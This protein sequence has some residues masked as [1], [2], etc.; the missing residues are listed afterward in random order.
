MRRTPRLVELSVWV[1]RL[2]LAAYPPA[3]RHEYSEAMAQLFRDCALDAYWRHGPL[4]LLAMWLR[5]LFDFTRSVIREHRE[6]A[7]G[8]GESMSLLFLVQQWLTLGGVLLCVMVESVRYTLH[9][10]LSRPGRTCAIAST[11]IL[12]VWVWSFFAKIGSFAIKPLPISLHCQ[13][14]G[15][16]M[17]FRHTYDVGEPDLF[18]ERF[19]PDPKYRKMSGEDMAKL[20]QERYQQNP[21][22]RIKLSPLRPW[23]FSYSSGYWV[24]VGFKPRQFSLLRVPVPALLVF[25]LL[26]YLGTR[27]RLRGNTNSTLAMQLT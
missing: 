13:I 24:L 11:I 20:I 8:A 22:Y 21:K 4:G 10:I 18:P 6:T 16:V 14:A 1:Y 3:I 12:L 17:I 23:E 26:F 27:G 5:I 19:G 25:V 2:L 9:V 7:V 15:G